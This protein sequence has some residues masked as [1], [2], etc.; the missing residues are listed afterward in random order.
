MSEHRMVFAQPQWS[1]LQFSEAVT[2][3]RGQ[4]QR[5]QQQTDNFKSLKVLLYDE[6]IAVFSVKLF[7]LSAQHCH[8]YLAANDQP[9]TLSELKAQCDAY[10][11][12]NEDCF[13]GCVPLKAS[14]IVR[15]QTL[16]DCWPEQGTV[17]FFTSGSTS[18]ARAVT[19]QWFQ[20]NRELERLEELFPCDRASVSLATVGH[21]HIYGLLF[22]LL[23]PLKQG[24]CIYPR[25][26]Y[27]EHLLPVLKQQ[28]GVLVSSPAHL[29]RLA[30]DNTLVEVRQGLCK[31]FSSGG[32]LADSVALRLASQLK[33]PVTQIYGSTESG[34]IAWRQLVDEPCPWQPFPEIRVENHSDG[35]VLY[36]PWADDR[37]LLLTDWGEVLADGR[38]Q[39]LG[40]TD[41]T[42]K[43]EEKRLDLN[44]MES[45]LNQHCWVE[46]CRLLPLNS[47][48]RTVLGA[49]VLLTSEGKVALRKMGNWQVKQQLRNYL[50][51]Y[52]EL[53]CLPKKWRYPSQLP[54]NTQGKTP[55]AELE[56]LFD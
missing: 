30:V 5:Y 41:R 36:S 37:P 28:S 25:F 54:V 49:V 40:R 47:Q 50:H 22:A 34:G 7:A 44:V 19:K 27:P 18:K 39:L 17:S 32:P 42:I 16:M 3:Y 9:D 51:G 15:P 55:L 48:S 12:P 8:I 33:Q 23:L 56:A 21:Q 53:I 35:L 13:S 38:F 20:L 2:A 1:L 24:L 10:A 4:I 43:L 52:F 14:Q 29:K 6:D 46:E 11:L 45:R 26:A 31:V